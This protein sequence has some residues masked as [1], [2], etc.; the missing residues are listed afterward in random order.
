[1]SADTAAPQPKLLKARMRHTRFFVFL[2]VPIILFGFGLHKEDSLT[3]EVM[4]WTGYFLVIVCVLGRG[5]CSA[6]IGGIKNEVV[7]RDGPFSIVRNPLYV[8]SFLGVVGIG[9][10]SG[11]FTLLGL[12][13]L[14]FLLYYPAVV[15]KEE[16]FLLHKFGEPYRHYTQ[17]V[18]RWIPKFSLW[19]E[20]KEMTTRPGFIRQTLL[21]ASLFFIAMP[22]FELLEALREMGYL[23]TFFMLP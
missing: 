12:L 11:M 18:P 15:K 3:H 17:E 6:F 1:M 16:A 20:P 23:P 8:F 22:C 5:Y 4:E 21:D 19:R 2:L 9:L 7:M 13:V 14:A 10:Q